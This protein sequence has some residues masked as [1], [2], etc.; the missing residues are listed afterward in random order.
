MRTENSKTYHLIILESI[1]LSGTSNRILFICEV[2]TGAAESK[3]KL[4]A[5]FVVTSS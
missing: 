5:L 3:N 1:H 2:R 4:M